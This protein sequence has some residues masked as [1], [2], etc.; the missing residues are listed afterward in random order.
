[1]MDAILD[2]AC[3]V[4]GFIEHDGEC[5]HIVSLYGQVGAAVVP[6]RGRE[7]PVAG[8]PANR[9]F[10]AEVLDAALPWRVSRDD[11]DAWCSR[12][13]DLRESAGV[14]LGVPVDPTKLQIALRDVPRDGKL[15]AGAA[16]IGGVPSLLL[17]DGT[18]RLIVA[19]LGLADGVGGSPVLGPPE[20]TRVRARDG[21]TEENARLRAE[22]AELRARIA[23]LEGRDGGGR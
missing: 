9:A 7:S 5:Y 21:L 23:R 8:I 4:P 17:D 2:E 11:L 14:V 18:R 13:V 12:M 16:R 19:G 15:S 3:L 20:F 10:V 1:M 6:G 22:N